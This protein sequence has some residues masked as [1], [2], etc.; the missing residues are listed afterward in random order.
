MGSVPS[1][2]QILLGYYFVVYKNGICRT[3]TE[4]QECDTIFRIWQNRQ[5][6]SNL[7]NS[8]RQSILPGSTTPAWSTWNILPGSVKWEQNTG[9]K[10]SYIIPVVQLSVGHRACQYQYQYQ[11]RC[12]STRTGTGLCS[13]TYQYRYCT[14]VTGTWYSTGWYQGRSYD[15]SRSYGSRTCTCSCMIL[16]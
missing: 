14:T 5:N 9:R 13:S 8:I 12:T 1:A 11:Y 16:G 15:G 7:W 6:R 3:Q 10:V 2:E 4:L